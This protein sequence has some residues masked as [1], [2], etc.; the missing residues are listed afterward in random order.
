MSHYFNKM[1]S[2]KMKLGLYLNHVVSFYDLV[3]II[4][5][6]SFD[7]KFLKYFSKFRTTSTK[8]SDEI[9]L[10]QLIEDF[11]FAFKIGSL[12]KALSEEYKSRIEILDC[13]WDIRL[14]KPNFQKFLN[15]LGIKTVMQKVYYEFGNQIAFSNSNKFHDQNFIFNKTDEIF[16]SLS[17]TS[18]ILNI[19]VESIVIGDLIYDT[20]LRYYHKPTIEVLDNDLKYLI[21]LSLDIFY[22]FKYFLESNKVNALVQVY[23]TYITHGITARIC[24]KMGIKVF[25]V[26]SDSYIL[27]EITKEFPYHGINHTTFST[28]SSINDCE[29]NMSKNLLELRFNGGVDNATSYMKMSSYFQSNNYESLKLLFQ[30]RQRN[31][32]IYA[33]DF[34]DSP[35][36]NRLLQFDDLFK[37]LEET[38]VYL[39]TL[40]NSSIFIKIHPNGLYGADIVAKNLVKKFENPNFYILDKDVSNLDIIKLNPNI[41][42]TAR[43]TIGIEMAYFSIPVV[44]LYDNI[45][46]NFDFVHNCQ[47]K[48]E[49]FKVLSGEIS[50]NCNFNKENIYKFYYQAY[51]ESIKEDSC[52]ILSKIKCKNVDSYSIEYIKKI[53]NKMSINDIDI[54][55]QLYKMTLSN[56]KHD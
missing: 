5:Y 49:Y 3:K 29:L 38:L 2:F 11:E 41:I 8:K 27:Q 43:G 15:I 28:N 16:C 54:L 31:I 44:A 53:S 33:H 22:S 21:R 24:L 10:V 30:K 47:S 35:H 32:V 18:D 42:G 52:Q 51:L 34:F 20:Y 19:E 26:A 36:V 55:N 6:L 50:A 1:K 45:Y 7:N 46:I 12:A 25:C 17:S 9:I 39:N 13:Y 37:F 4:L 48:D 56:N 23:T 40:N 14:N